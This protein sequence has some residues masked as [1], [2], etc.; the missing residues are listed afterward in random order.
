MSA[1]DTRYYTLWAY[2]SNAEMIHRSGFSTIGDILCHDHTSLFG[3]V[4][5]LNPQV[6]ALNALGNTCEGIKPVTSWRKP[7]DH[8][9]N[10]W[11]NDVQEDAN[12]ILPRV[13]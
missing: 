1:I 8:P 4:A 11:L 9:C 6:S 13:S 5:C 12:T 2:V 3:H 7:L 10:T